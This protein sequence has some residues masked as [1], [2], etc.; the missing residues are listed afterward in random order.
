MKASFS[1]TK[2][3]FKEH[4]LYSFLWDSGQLVTSKMI[5]KNV[6]YYPEDKLLFIMTLKAF[7]SGY[8]TFYS[9]FLN[10]KRQIYENQDTFIIPN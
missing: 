7:L 6:I 5:I 8:Q 10:L 9:I 2:S 4:C 3:V 1:E